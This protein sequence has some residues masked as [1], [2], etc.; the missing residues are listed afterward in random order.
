MGLSK[1]GLTAVQYALTY[2]QKIEK[3]ITV[4]SPL[5]GTQVASYHPFC[6]VTRNELGYESSFIQELKAK[7]GN[8]NKPAIYSIVPRWDHLIIPVESA[9]F[10]HSEYYHYQGWYSHVGILYAP[11]V[12]TI[13]TKWL[14]D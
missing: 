3:V 10:P 6:Q 9:K 7:F 11:E 5:N 13:I 4:S 2:P 14:Q 12:I 1:G 8:N